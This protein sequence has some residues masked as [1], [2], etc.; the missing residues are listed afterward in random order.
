MPATFE[1]SPKQSKHSF[2]SYQR[3]QLSKCLQPT[4]EGTHMYV[5]HVIKDI[6][7]FV[8]RGRR[9]KQKEPAAIPDAALQL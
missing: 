9:N 6:N 8:L 4:D 1:V 7:L 3:L 5:K 2:A